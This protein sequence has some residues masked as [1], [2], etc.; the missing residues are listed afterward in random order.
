MGKSKKKGNE[1]KHSVGFAVHSRQLRENAERLKE[2]EHQK[3][4]K[5]VA[6]VHGRTKM[7]PSEKPREKLQQVLDISRNLNEFIH[8]YRQAYESMKTG[9]VNQTALIRSLEEVIDLSAFGLE[10]KDLVP[11]NFQPER[12]IDLLEHAQKHV[13]KI[14]PKI[15]LLTQDPTKLTVNLLDDILVESKRAL[16]DIVRDKEKLQKQGKAGNYI[17][18]MIARGFSDIGRTIASSTKKE[19]NKALQDEFVKEVKSA[20]QVLVSGTKNFVGLF[21]KKAAEK[22]DKAAAKHLDVGS[23]QSKFKAEAQTMKSEEAH[24][25]KHKRKHK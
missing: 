19:L 16:K 24:L 18:A 12:M 25:G 3:R 6:H 8:I 4:S 17:C 13:H 20:E 7:N 11:D 2:Q 15:E 22:L 14:Q 10:I 5:P 1:S 21:S 9:K 23:F